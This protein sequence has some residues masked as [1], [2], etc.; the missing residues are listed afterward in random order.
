MHMSTNVSLTY[1]GLKSMLIENRYTE[2]ISLL[3]AKTHF[4]FPGLTDI[5]D[6]RQHVLPN[7]FDS[8]RVLSID[9]EPNPYFIA[10][11]PKMRVETWNT[12]SQMKGLQQLRVYIKTLCVLPDSSAARSL[13]Q[14]LRKVK[15]L[16]KFEL[17]V[18]RDQFAFWDGFLEEGMEV[19]LVVNTEA[20]G[21]SS[22]RQ[23]P[24]PA[25]M[26]RAY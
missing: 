19:K 12:I 20:R 17:V 2:T 9:W 22:F 8:I 15:G 4:H 5:L 1:P 10:S 11:T 14:N 16:Q 24:A 23:P 25:S 7:R 18:T 3:Y 13:K 26:V 6:F 21:E